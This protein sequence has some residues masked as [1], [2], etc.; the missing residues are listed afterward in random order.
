M[1]IKIIV[2]DD[3]DD[4]NDIIKDEEDLLDNDNIWLGSEFLVK[5]NFLFILKNIFLCDKDI[6]SLFSKVKFIQ[7]LF[8][9]VY[10]AILWSLE[11]M[12]NSGN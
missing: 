5:R 7:Y 6:H 3:Y 12:L 8:K 4:W 10:V 9:K 1:I 2:M 11:F